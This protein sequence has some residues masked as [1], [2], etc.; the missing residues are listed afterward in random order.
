M[1]LRVSGKN[2]DIGDALRAHCQ[3]KVM[4][5]IA[6]YFDG[7]VSGHVTIEPEGSGYRAE[8]TLHLASGMTL[9]ADGAGHEPYASFD[10]A[11]GRIE[12]RLRRYKGRLKSHGPGAAHDEPAGLIAAT[13]FEAIDDF[14][15]SVAF[16]PVVV[17]ET[18]AALKTMA[19]STAVLDLDLSG[20]PVLVF[21][22]AHSGRV[23]IV[24]RRTDGNIGWLD[25]MSGAAGEKA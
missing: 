16:S 5:A 7:A 8:C 10:Q 1:S 9:H 25:P 19:V 14:E 3:A 4:G 20:A 24:Y 6:K 17:A 23:N 13:V 22:H 11:A 12:K 2:I 15:D 21:R 18:T